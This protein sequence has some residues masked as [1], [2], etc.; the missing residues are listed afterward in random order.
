M[1]RRPLS[2]HVWLALA[3][4]FVIAVPALAGVAAWAAAGSWQAG[5]Q[6]HRE[7]QAKALLRNATLDSPRASDTITRGLAAIGVEAEL[8]PTIPD[9]KFAASADSKAD[10]DAQKT[11]VALSKP[12][13]FTPALQNPDFKGQ[14]PHYR[15]ITFA[16]D[17]VAGFLFIP[18]ESAATRWAIAARSRS[19]CA[20][21]ARSSRSMRDAP[22]CW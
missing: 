20:S 11:K 7:R 22:S 4:A 6:D 19:T 15:Q 14:L 9:A 3:L 21:C 1:T 16:G 18:S 17:N 12:V 5:R 8:G 10:V 2:L 13:L